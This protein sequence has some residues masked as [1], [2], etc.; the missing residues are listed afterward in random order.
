MTHELSPD[1]LP[2]AEDVRAEAA[3]W[4]GGSPASGG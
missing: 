4:L 3:A 2:G 1:L